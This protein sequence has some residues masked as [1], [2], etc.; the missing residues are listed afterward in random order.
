[1]VKARQGKVSGKPK[2][3]QRNEN[4]VGLSPKFDTIQ[5]YL[6][7]EHIRVAFSPYSSF[8]CYYSNHKTC[9]A[10]L[11]LLVLRRIFTH[12]LSIKLIHLFCLNGHYTPF[13]PYL[14][15][16]PLAATT[17][18]TLIFSYILSFN[19]SYHL[20]LNRASRGSS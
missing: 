12:F 17:H 8:F 2:F 7:N 20:S 9:V 13:F 11:T 14:S 5:Y 15:L 18:F 16:L 6:I 1:M 19:T 3:N 4:F 10:T